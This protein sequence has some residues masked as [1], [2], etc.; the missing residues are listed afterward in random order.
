M[1]IY[2]IIKKKSKNKKTTMI[3]NEEFLYKDPKTSHIKITNIKEI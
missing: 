2:S 3:I 1:C